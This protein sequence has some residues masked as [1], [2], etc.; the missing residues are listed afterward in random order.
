[1]RVNIFRISVRDVRFFSQYRCNRS[2]EFILIHND[3]GF[4]FFFFQPH[5]FFFL[6]VARRALL[7]VAPAVR[8]L[9]AQGRTR[10]RPSRADKTHNGTQFTAPNKCEP[11]IR[12][13]S[14]I[15]LCLAVLFIKIELKECYQIVIVISS[16]DYCMN[17]VR[18][19][20]YFSQGF[21]HVL[22]I[23]AFIHL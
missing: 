15:Q 8:A 7:C 4:H 10:T 11:T 18:G 21:P 2:I 17:L 19:L 5:F 6:G 20:K 14:G 1:M 23:H 16:I 22:Q 3:T 13:I 9:C 12:N